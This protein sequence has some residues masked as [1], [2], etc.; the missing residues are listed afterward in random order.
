MVTYK[1]WLCWHAMTK[2]GGKERGTDVEVGVHCG[3]LRCRGS[4]GGW[5]FFLFLLIPI[6]MLWKSAFRSL[7]SHILNNDNHNSRLLLFDY[8]LNI[9]YPLI[10][11]VSY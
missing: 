6:L 2:C 11:G 9:P 5:S 3:G 8:H 7:F 1:G 4:W 10:L